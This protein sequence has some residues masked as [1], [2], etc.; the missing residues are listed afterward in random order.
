M[1]TDSIRKQVDCDYIWKK[2][3]AG[4]RVWQ[5]GR[6]IG[7]N[8]DFIQ[9][10]GAD[11]RSQPIIIHTGKNDVMHDSCTTTQNRLQIEDGGQFAASPL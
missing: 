2:T 9:D 1:I 7:A 10:S 4:I 3:S 8:V 5:T 6:K 11:L